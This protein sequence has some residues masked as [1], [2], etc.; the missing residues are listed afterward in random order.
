MDWIDYRDKL[1][2]GFC[3]K[4]KFKYLKTKVFNVLNII[5]NTD[6]MSHLK[7]NE[8]I[9]FC[10]MTGMPLDVS[11][12]NEYMARKRF[13]YC[14]SVVE[15]ATSLK[16][17]LAYY[18]AFINVIE[19]VKQTQE[20]WTRKKYVNLICKCMNEAHIQFDLLEDDGQYFIFPRGA[21]ELDNA[22][23]SEPLEW[24]YQYPRARNTFIIALK[25]YSEGV[26]IR[27]TADNLRKALE[28]FLQEFLGNTKNLETNKIEI[29]NYLKSQNVDS[30]IT[31]LFHSLI[32]AY[33]NLNDRT[34]KHNDRVDEKLLEFLL[35]QTGLLIR[36]VIVIK[37][38]EA[39]TSKIG[40]V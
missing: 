22:L 27:D 33:K 36:M 2:V 28:A 24:L 17:F 29:G 20:Q 12:C 25:Q 23:V 18:V 16:D 40:S 8:Y 30:N 11:Y 35:Y 39:D 10:N 3:D 15:R 34:A 38:G 6:N 1:G 19:P 5:L 21:I 26:Y 9:A 7:S 31:G 32:S 14:L 4:E 13:E 37:K